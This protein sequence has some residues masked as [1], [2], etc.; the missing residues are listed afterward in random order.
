MT[1]FAMIAG[2]LPLALGDTIGAEYRKAL[3]TVVIGGLSTSLFLTLFVVP[4][5]YVWHRSKDPRR[6]RSNDDPA[7]FSNNVKERRRDVAFP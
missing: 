6:A 4:A 1:T 5:A 3:G 2:M 7:T